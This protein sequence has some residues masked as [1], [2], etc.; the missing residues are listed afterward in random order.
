MARDAAI[1]EHLAR[2]RET[3]GYKQ[4]E[5]A[6]RI[7]CSP[8]VLS[9][10]EGGER[11]ASPE[12]LDALLA[13]IGTPEAQ[14]FAECL[15]RHWS[16]IPEPPFDEP[17]ADLIW[18]AEQAAVAV[19]ALAAQPDVKHF[20]ERRLTRYKEELRASAARLTNRRYYVVFSG[21][22]AAGKSTAICRIESL[23]VVDGKGRPLPVIEV[24]P[25]GITLCEVHVRRGP[26]YGFIVD[27]CS[28][29]E[30]RRHVLDF[31][32]SLL[33][34]SSAQTGSETEA[35]SG[36]A[37]SSREISRAL[38]NM[39]DLPIRRFPRKQ[40][41]TKPPS[42]DEG[43]VLAARIGEIKALAV[44]ILARMQLHRRDRRDIWHSPATE[45]PPLVWLQGIF[46]KVNNGA[47]A[48][49]SLPKRMEIVVPH[50]PL[51]E[52][53][54]SITL[55][56]TQGIDDV[57]GRVDLEQHFDDP[58]T[59]VVLCTKFE[60]A[61]SVHIR[62]LLTRAREAGVRTL[63]SHA[64][65]LVLPRP[66]EAMQMKDAGV[67]VGTAEEG[68][69]IKADEI[70]LKLNALGLA[71]L[72]LAFFNA[73]EDDP[74]VLRSFL[75]ARIAAVRDRHRDSLREIVAGANAL[76]AN[77]EKEQAREATRE[78]ARQLTRWLRHNGE[79]TERIS[80]HVHDSLLTATASAYPQ[81]IN[82]A[83][84]RE[85]NW[86]K[87]NYGHNLS[88]GARR[89]AAQ[90]AERKLDSFREI[91]KHL[92]LDEKLTDAHDLVRQAL[93]V[94][95]AGFDDLIR[96]VQLVGQSIHADELIADA[97]FWRDCEREWGRGSGYRDRV[98]THN[99]EWFEEKRG[100]EADRRVLAVIH[101][102]WKNAIASVA[103]LLPE[104]AEE[105]AKDAAA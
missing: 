80:R 42:V 65:V 82:A 48:E 47:D 8:A 54:L 6:K 105:G 50:A 33:E 77:Y 13:A 81:T 2:L 40:D 96:K 74:G 98:N 68:C 87:L 15:S 4:N 10:I 39:A 21:A 45:K 52:D 57:A 70:R 51:R 89:M 35:D 58:H 32:R 55:I 95:E 61:P 92:L 90:A 53:V 101:E 104:P 56:D 26:G 91:A 49:F 85:G 100:H 23:E 29:Y 5:L 41:G 1:G 102:E 34:S 60:E 86:H 93:R 73:A 66:G 64:A 44:E 67:P 20:F 22:I 25:G 17:D 30:V 88:H 69:E 27:P 24:G 59:V 16:I 9:R 75:Q 37:G 18:E 14:A 43:R 84:V 12:E 103:Q 83:V 7:Q 79:L 31:A 63:D 11:P 71:D 28:E 78:A 3:A 46:N 94:L 76:L 62:Q 38:R 19:E 99:K 97:E 72:A 36:L